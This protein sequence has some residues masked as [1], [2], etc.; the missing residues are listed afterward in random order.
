MIASLSKP[1]RIKLLSE[2]TDDELAELEYDWGFWSRS[3]QRA[4]EGNWTVWV[5]LAGRGFGKT[6]SGAE[7]VR[8]M[9]CGTTPL[10]RGLIRHMAIVGETA[11]DVRDVMV[12]DGAEDASG[13]LQVH[14]K[15][16]R[17]KYEVSKR[18]L[19]WP[20]GAIAT[21]YN[22]TEPE[23]L[24]GPQHGGAWCD[25]LAKWRY[26]VDTWD[27]LEFGLRLGDPRVCIT[28]T[29]KP[30][31]KLKEILSEPGTEVTTGSTYDNAANLSGKFLKRIE[32]Y[33]GTRIGRQE[34]YAELLEDVPGALWAR[35]LLDELRVK[36]N[37]TPELQRVVVG[38]DPGIKSGEDAD[39]TGIVCVGLGVDGH[40]Y[41]LED[42]SRNA[43]PTE[44]ANEAISVYRARS[45]DRIVAEVNQGGEMVEN[46]LRMVDKTV[47]YKGV[48]AS[49]GKAIRA[50]PVS[51]LYERKL[52]HH[53][54][55]FQQLE[56]QMTAF[57]PDFNREE[58]GYSPDRLDALVWAITEL[59]IDAGD[60]VMTAD[61]GVII[62]PIPL[63]R[64]FRRVVGLDMTRKHVAAV[65]A[66]YDPYA[67]K[68][69]IYDEYIVRRGDI[70]V[71]AGAM[72]GRGGWIPCIFEPEGRGRSQDE[73]DRIVDRLMSF[74]MPIYEEVDGDIE[75]CIEDMNGRV[76]AKTLKVFRGSCPEWINQ[77]RNF[78]RDHEG[79]L[80]E[81]D[82]GLIHATGL[83]CARGLEIAIT[84][85]NVD[86]DREEIAEDMASQSRDKVTGY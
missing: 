36:P 39:E 14:P 45:A 20:N 4:P 57:T 23:T 30:V 69:Y 73:G 15:D 48:H 56:D 46:T 42:Q 16:Y 55:A 21:C 58:A 52:V 32:K 37:E 75:A 78:R 68:V 22:A 25:E 50:E 49:R 61:D 29:P 80:T 12:G 6:R 5:I 31:K 47:P 79:E 7:W 83:L 65:W 70:A 40:V 18:R 28:T 54:G 81:E 41:V 67:K 17:P 11:A 72:K 13:I 85:H 27:N 26:L 51:A 9:M 33:E 66:A 8:S 43:S 63:P 82:N 1:E 59:A 76:S 44:W 60:T 34:L 19:T 53:V 71:H 77:Y 62:D 2:L 24:R 3:N 10:G 35:S 74:S 38:I 84:D 64:H 86:R